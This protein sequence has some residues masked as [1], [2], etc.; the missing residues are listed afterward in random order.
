MKS[1]LVICNAPDQDTARHIARTLVEERLAACVNILPACRSVYRWQGELEEDS[2]L[3]LLIKTTEEAYPALQHRLVV[4][5][6]YEVPEIIAV[7]I[8]H[9]LPAYLTLVCESVVSSQ[10][11]VDS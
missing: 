8:A 7:E 3:P 6:P 1:M 10:P 5:H 2:E 11:E 4:L 9:V